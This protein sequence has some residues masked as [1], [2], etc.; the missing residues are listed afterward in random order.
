MELR[1]DGQR[2]ELTRTFTE[3]YRTAMAR[4]RERRER[5]LRQRRVECAANHDVKLLELQEELRH[6]GR[7]LVEPVRKAIGA[8]TTFNAQLRVRLAQADRLW[9]QH[10]MGSNV[11]PN[12][13]VESETTG[14][15]TRQQL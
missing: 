2:E 6:E 15:W 7:A 11:E 9:Q 12:G 4:L 1:L 13:P 3:K 14:R 10:C 5:L 8:R